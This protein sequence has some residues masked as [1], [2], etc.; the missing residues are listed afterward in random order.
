M[1]SLRTGIGI[2][3]AARLEELTAL[4]RSVYATAPILESALSP[5][6][7]SVIMTRERRV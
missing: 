4:I 6:Y 7:V 2:A 3:N 5:S 1:G